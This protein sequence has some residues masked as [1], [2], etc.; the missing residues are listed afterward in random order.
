MQ[1]R[2]MGVLEDQL[3][4]TKAGDVLVSVFDPVHVNELAGDRGH[5]KGRASASALAIEYV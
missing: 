2:N 1:R 3:L 4:T 5:R